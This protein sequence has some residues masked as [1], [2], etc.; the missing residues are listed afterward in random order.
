[1]TIIK[2]CLVAALALAAGAA[3]EAARADEAYV[4]DQG[5]VVYVKPGEL[6]IK[7]QQDPCIARYFDNIPSSKPDAQ[8]AAAAAG[9]VAASAPSPAAPLPPVPAATAAPKSEPSSDFRKVRIINADPGSDGWFRH[10]R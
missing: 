2:G 9:R 8:A 7:K 4:C 1:M 5:R 3:V 10:R 6:E